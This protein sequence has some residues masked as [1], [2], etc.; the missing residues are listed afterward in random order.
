MDNP[1]PSLKLIFNLREKKGLNEKAIQG[2]TV[3][4]KVPK[5]RPRKALSTNRV[6]NFINAR[7]YKAKPRFGMVYSEE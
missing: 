1:C 2:C 7:L 4:E 6:Q 3:P 5:A